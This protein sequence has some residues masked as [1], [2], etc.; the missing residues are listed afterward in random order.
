LAD[1]LSLPQRGGR[2]AAQQKLAT[3]VGVGSI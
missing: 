3:H 1:D 2:C